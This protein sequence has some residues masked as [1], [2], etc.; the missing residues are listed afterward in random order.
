MS[1]YWNLICKIIEFIGAVASI[2]ASIRGLLA[3]LK[4]RKYIDEL[5]DELDCCIID[6]N[7]LKNEREN[8]KSITSDSKNKNERTEKYIKKMQE[9]FKKTKEVVIKTENYLNSDKCCHFIR[10]IKYNK[11]KE[12]LDKIIKFDYNNPLA[13]LQFFYGKYDGFDGYI[14]DLKY[15]RDN[16]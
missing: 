12:N 2:V 7:D 14:K 1:N 4:T 5:K 15:I 9:E 13:Y 3:L 11:V 8:L 10:K 16:I 6:I